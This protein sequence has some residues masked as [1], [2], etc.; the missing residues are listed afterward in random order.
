MYRI[1]KSIELANRLVVARG[2]DK[3]GI[4][5]DLVWGLFFGVF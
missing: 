4:E 5:S 2:R 3:R 1:G